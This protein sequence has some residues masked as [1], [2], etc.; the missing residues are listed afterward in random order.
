[1][2][3]KDQITGIGTIETYTMIYSRN[4]NPS[5]AV[6]YG[7]TLDNCRFIARTQNHPEIFKQ[8]TSENMIGQKI[9]IAFNPSK[10]MNIADFA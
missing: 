3:I 8:L 5:Y 7:R 1:M 2:K 4:Q 10:N 6:I 9:K